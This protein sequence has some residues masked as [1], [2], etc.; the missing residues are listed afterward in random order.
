MPDSRRTRQQDPLWLELK[1]KIEQVVQLTTTPI[2][3]GEADYQWFRVANPDC[4][5]E[6][7]VSDPSQ[8]AHEIDPFWAAT[9]RA[10]IGLDQFLGR[11]DLDECRVL[12]LGCGSGQAGVGAATRGARVTMTDVVQLALQ[13]AELNAWEVADRLRFRYLDW[14]SEDGLGAERFP[15]IIGSDLVYDPTLFPLLDQCARNHIAS[16]GTLYLSEPHRHTG[17]HFSR[18]VQQAGWKTEEVD[19]DLDDGRVPIRIFACK[20]G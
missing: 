13:V 11:L 5:L 17:D 16:D 18:W 10:A 20:L 4:L 9:W 7:A 1:R 19:V 3:L 14:A 15:I 6:Q 2:R 12:E 8:P